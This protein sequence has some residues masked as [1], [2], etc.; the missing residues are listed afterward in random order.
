MPEY[1][2]DDDE[3]EFEDDEE[4]ETS[5]CTPKSFSCPW[6]GVLLQVL[7]LWPKLPQYEHFLAIPIFSTRQ[8]KNMPRI[9]Y[10]LTHPHNT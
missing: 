3:K 5:S 6:P 9:N 2:G 8:I 7:A 1:E 10:L 4:E